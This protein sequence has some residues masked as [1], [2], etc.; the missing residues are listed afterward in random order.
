[1]VSGIYSGS[2]YKDPDL[3]AS[4]PGESRSDGSVS[5]VKTHWP[6]FADVV[7]PRDYDKI[8]LVLRD[9]VAAIR[10]SYIFHKSGENHTGVLQPHW[11]FTGIETSSIIIQVLL[12]RNI[13]QEDR[14]EPRM[15]HLIERQN[16]TRK[17]SPN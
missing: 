16:D 7:D 11:D 3:V 6:L 10:S 17:M 1:L 12:Y 9:P 14:L 5:V 8:I 13:N 15:K 4:F 2:I